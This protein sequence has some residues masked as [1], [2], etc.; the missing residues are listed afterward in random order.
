MRIT[1]QLQSSVT[2]QTDPTDRALDIAAMFGLPI[3]GTHEHVILPPITLTLA[4]GQVVFVTGVS[5]GGKSTL[6]RTISEALEAAHQE[7]DAD[8]RPGLIW[9][10]PAAHAAQS[11]PG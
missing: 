3:D 10:R 6:L 5:G 2:T 9:N 11:T 4:P 1:L 8:M 7:E